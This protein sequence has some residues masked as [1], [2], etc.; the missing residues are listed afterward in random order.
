VRK[1]VTAP[2]PADS[3]TPL[4]GLGEDAILARI[5]PL[6]RG[7]AAAH[8]AGHDDVLGG[9][10]DDAAVVRVPGTVVLT[11]D[12]MIRGRDWR[13]DWSSPAD[14]A[15]KLGAQNISDIAAMGAVA[16]A[17]LLTVTADPATPVAWV[18]RFAEGL[19][20]WCAAAAVTVVGGDLSSA[21]EGV[22]QVSLT[23][24]GD[25]QGRAPVLRSGAGPGDVVAVCGSLGRSSAGLAS[26]QT[27]AV[28]D[29]TVA[30]WRRYHRR[31]RP[32]WE[33]GP[34]AAGAGATAMI[35][36]SD[37]LVR[38]AG[39]V[40]AASGVRLDLDRRALDEAFV[41]TLRH[42]HT[43]AQ[44]W[45]HV[46]GGGEEHSLLAT[47][48]A[49]SGPPHTPEAPWRVIGS[50]RSGGPGVTLDG[51]P[52]EVLGWDHF[53]TGAPENDNSRPPGR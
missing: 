8:P 29:G 26:L 51:D 31:P 10:G 24:W 50:V 30:A 6:L 4:A 53:E 46:L 32:P 37:G 42:R 17:A 35:D 36:L 7:G 33:A 5:L 41:A 44:A 22:L 49:E 1:T 21:P 18:E 20:D 14:V 15:H 9:P 34:V 48:P 28:E 25:L 19:G 12:S 27:D 39:R 52:L 23:M 11:T 16:T 2:D 38:D 43:E 3:T 45:H 40:A 47:F 13:D